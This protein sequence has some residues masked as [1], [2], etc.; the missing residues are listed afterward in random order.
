MTSK[1]FPLKIIFHGNG[2]LHNMVRILVGTIIEIGEGKRLPE[3]IP[4]ILVSKD[5]AMAGETSPAQGL[6]LADV[7]YD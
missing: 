4:E 7:Y 2:F 5:R 1:L 6:F 3:S